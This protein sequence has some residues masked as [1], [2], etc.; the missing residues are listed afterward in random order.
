VASTNLASPRALVQIGA[1]R[2][3]QGQQTGGKGT[4]GIEAR[5]VRTNRLKGAHP[6]E[7]KVHGH[8]GITDREPHQPPNRRPVSRRSWR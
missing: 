4:D 1:I 3:D 7:P 5:G 6:V 2:T 8:K